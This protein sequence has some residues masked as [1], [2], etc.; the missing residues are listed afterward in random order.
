MSNN[1]KNNNTNANNNNVNKVSPCTCCDQYCC[2]WN[3]WPFKNVVPNHEE[4]SIPKDVPK[5][6]LVV[7]VG[8]DEYYKRFVIKI[9][10]L[11]HPLF[12]ALLDQ[13]RDEFDYVA[14]PKL[15]IP[16]DESLFLNVVRCAT[17]PDDASCL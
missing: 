16:C 2:Q 7:Y 3:L 10:L 8:K 12:K 5:G 4:V 17:C 6:H 11:N 15:C 9:G 14:G 13:A 1:K